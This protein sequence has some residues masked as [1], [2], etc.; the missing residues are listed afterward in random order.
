MPLPESC[1]ASR[2]H[3]I[4]QYVPVV[5]GH[6]GQWNVNGACHVIFRDS[7][8]LLVGDHVMGIFTIEAGD[9]YLCNSG[10]LIC[11]ED[12]VEFKTSED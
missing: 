3:G 10:V 9:G 4:F 5:L 11:Q 1:Q 7:L 12:L 8:C 6:Y 2:E